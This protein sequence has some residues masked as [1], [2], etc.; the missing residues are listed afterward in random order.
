MKRWMALFTVFLLLS[1]IVYGATVLEYNETDYINVRPKATDPDSDRLTYFFDKPLS[2]DGTWQTDFG[3][4]GIYNTKVTVSDGRLLTVENI[5]IIVNRKEVAPVIEI[6][7]PDKEELFIQEGDSVFFNVKAT[8]INDDNLE[9]IWKLDGESVHKGKYYTYNTDY[10]SAGNHN[11]SV[12]VSD[13]IYE[14]TK[15]WMVEVDSFDRAD[16]LGDLK[17]IT[18]RESEFINMNV[19]DFDKY[20]LEFNIS[21]PLGNDGKWQTTYDD[22]GVY[23]ITIEVWDNKEFFAIKRIKILVENTDRRPELLETD[24]YWIY[25]GDELQV[26][27]DYRDPDGDEVSV[28]AENL[29]EGAYFEYGTFKWTPVFDTVTKENL[30]DDIARRIHAMNRLFTI[31]VDASS[32]NLTTTQEI[33]IRVFNKNRAPVLDD[34]PEVV[35]LAGETIQYELTASDPDNDSLS[36]SFD[37]FREGYQVTNAD[38][39]IYNVKVTVSDGFL[40]D[41]KSVKVKVLGKNEPPTLQN[42]FYETINENDQLEITLD[43]TDSDGDTLTYSVIPKPK[44]SYFKDNVFYWKPGFDEVDENSKET[45]LLFVAFDG[46]FNSSKSTV[47]T[48]NNVD[49][50]F[51]LTSTSQN[52]DMDYYIGDEITFF[53]DTFDPDN[54]ELQYTWRTSLFN[55]FEGNSTMKIKYAKEGKKS[56]EVTVSDGTIETSREWKFNVIKKPSVRIIP[57]N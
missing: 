20:D 2:S 8:D 17:S 44:N 28:S 37:G 19:P 56:V 5:T 23:T 22:E 55:S 7:A 49:R 12:V 14:S 29:P 21:E 35:V 3:D 16:L 31:I 24:D 41:T 11:V 9:V 25:E 26:L 53:V 15:E 52:D 13:G 34:I 40:T 50:P 4:E 30:I 48:I 43:A 46:E 18:V 42:I 47:I 32:N 1:V 54:D 27:L 39:G 33:T 51:T 10:Y 38:A 36:F 57:L 6:L 45:E